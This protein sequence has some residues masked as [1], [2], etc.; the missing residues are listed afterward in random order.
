ME[1]LGSLNIELTGKDFERALLPQG[2]QLLQ[3]V[4]GA[5]EPN[6][7]GDNYNL[8]VILTNAN[9]TP[10]SKDGVMVEAGA[11]KLRTYNNIMQTEGQKT[12]G[13]DPLEGVCQVIDAVFK[14]DPSGRPN[15]N[16]ETAAGMAGNQV[17]GIITH[18]DDPTYGKQA[19]VARL[20]PVE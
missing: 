15:L 5:I 12:A 18:D 1:P 7:R 17:I 8:V 9:P 11:A 3:V 2:Q 4:S 19:R 16:A 20:L 10:S 6:K 14:C 13:V